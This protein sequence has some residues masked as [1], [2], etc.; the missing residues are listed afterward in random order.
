MYLLSGVCLHLYED[1]L[2]YANS[3]AT[4]NKWN[5]ISIYYLHYLLLYALNIYLHSTFQRITNEINTEK[6]IQHFKNNARYK[7]EHMYTKL[8]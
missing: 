7:V 3:P 1:H 6:Y 2:P 5:N 8:Y 4:E